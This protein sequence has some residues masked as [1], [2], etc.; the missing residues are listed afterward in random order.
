[1]DKLFT[2][3]IS[4]IVSSEKKIEELIHQLTQQTVA[5]HDVSVQGDPA[6]IAKE[7]GNTAVSPKSIQKN[8]QAPKK[9]AYLA[10]DF[11][12]VLGFSFSI[13]IFIGLIIGIFIIGDVGSLSDN[14]LFGFLGGLI[15]GLVGFFLNKLIKANHRHKR[16]QQEKKGGYVLWV[17]VTNEE[18]KTHVMEILKEHGAT[19]IMINK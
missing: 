18:Q 19:N 6:S 12:W 8:E 16:K 14:L 2:Q 17:T 13:P 11:G 1:M 3:K 5:H 10:D 15:G 4:A 9:E 7:F